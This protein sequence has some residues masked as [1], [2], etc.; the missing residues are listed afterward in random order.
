MKML[1]TIMMLIMI[2]SITILLTTK[3]N[4]MMVIAGFP[5]TVTSLHIATGRR[6]DLSSTIYLRWVG[7]LFSVFEV[8]L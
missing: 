1:K 3:I 2:M 6:R 5:R 4:L 7:W 8:H